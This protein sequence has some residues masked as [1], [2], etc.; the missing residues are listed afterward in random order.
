MLR[1]LFCMALPALLFAQDGYNA[2]NHGRLAQAYNHLQ[3]GIGGPGEIDFLR[4]A[5]TTNA[6]SAVAVYSQVVLSNSGSEISKRALDRIR[7][8]Y[9]AQ[10]YYGRADE[11]AKE[12]TGWELPQKRLRT[13]ESTPP[14]PFVLTSEVHP[15]P[16]K[17]Q[18]TEDAKTEDDSALYGLQVG[19]F[20]NKTNAQN[21]KKDLERLGYRIEILSPADNPTNL[22]MIRA[23]GYSSVE[24]AFAAAEKIQAKFNLKP[25]VISLNGEE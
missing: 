13:P 23:V 24:E 18:Q 16:E 7:Q 25:V 17:P 11:I 4:A 14:P 22:Y 20:S 19:A 10:G 15:I 2:Y 3:G 5:L 21:L 1:L 12:L 9:Y 8:Y 6:D